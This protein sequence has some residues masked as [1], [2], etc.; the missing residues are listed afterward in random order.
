MGW[1]RSL[2]FRGRDLPTS[3]PDIDSWGRRLRRFAARLSIVLAVNVG[4]LSPVVA[5]HTEA[6]FGQYT[7]YQVVYQFNRSDT[8]YHRSVL[9]SIS[10]LIRKHGDDIEIVVI[11]IGTGLHILGRSP[12]RPVEQEVKEKVQSLAD[13]GVNFRAC[14][15]TMKSLGWSSKDLFS[16]VEVVPIG[17]EALIDFQTRG[18]AYISW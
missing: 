15:N 18:F 1:L 6:H 4:C 11:A 3:G 14:G 9:F 13:Y 7:T 17:V 8:N 16:F 5:H 10:E 12:A 2:A